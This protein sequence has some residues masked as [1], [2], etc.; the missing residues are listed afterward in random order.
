MG[1]APGSIAESFRATLE[2]CETGLQLMR[3]NLRRRHP[4]IAE[5]DLER[6]VHAWR[7]ERP[8]AEAGDCPG[9]IRDVAT[10]IK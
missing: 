5:P 7:L 3:Q 6:L 9:R 10:V 1:P 2:L 4:G 8:G